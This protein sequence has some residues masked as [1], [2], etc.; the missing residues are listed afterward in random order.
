M[1]WNRKHLVFGMCV[2]FV[3][4]SAFAGAASAW[5]VGE[6]ES[7]HAAVGDAAVMPSYENTTHHHLLAFD[8]PPQIKEGR[9]FHSPVTPEGI[10]RDMDA[11]IVHTSGSNQAPEEEWNR[12]FGG[13]AGDEGYSVQQISDGEYIITGYT[14]S[15]GAGNA[16]VWLIKTDSGGNELWNR[17]FGGS[18]VD[19]GYSV[20]QISD[21]G[22][23]IA[24]TTS[25]YGAGREDVWLIKTDSEGNELWNRTFGG[26]SLDRGSSVQ[27][28]SDGGY[29]IAGETYSYGAGDYDAWLIKTDSE[30]NELWT[31]TFGGPDWDKG[32]S[33]QQTSDGEY[34]IT[35]YTCSYGAGSADV[36]LIKTDSEGNKEWSKTFGGSSG[37]EGYSVR[38]TSDGGYIITGWTESYGAG[39]YDVLLIKTDSEGNKEWSKTFGGS[40]EDW[41]NSVQQTSDGGYIIAGETKSYGAGSFDVWLIKVKGEEPTEL[42][43]HNLNTGEDFATIQA[44]IDDNDTKN[45]HTITVD[46]G[47]YTENVDVTKSLT[48]KSTSGNPEDT[49]VQAANPDD[50]VFEIT[51][52]YVN[53]SGFTVEGATGTWKAG[54]Y[55]NGAEYSNVSGNN[56]SGNYDGI[57]GWGSNNT[58]L[59]NIAVNNS[60]DGIYLQFETNTTL[61]NN[62]AISNNDSGIE[63]CHWSYNNTLIG[64]IA[65]NNTNGIF[66]WGSHYAIFRNNTM[67]GN[68]YN[69]GIGSYHCDFGEISEYIHDIDTSNTVDGKPIYYNIGAS[70]V[71]IDSSINAGYIAIVNGSNV[72]VKDIEM[73]NNVNGVLFALTSNSYI[74]NVNALNNGVGISLHCSQN[75]T[76]SG[77][78]IGNN[79]DGIEFYGSNN[80][81]NIISGNNI[82]DNRRGIALWLCNNNIVYLNNFINN[83]NNVYSY[84]STNTWNS[85]SKITYTYIDNQYTNYLGNYWDDYKGSDAN[86]D[87]IGDT[88]YSIG[89]D[90]DY[91]PLMKPFESYIIAP[92]VA[93]FDTGSPSNPYPS[94]AG[95]HKGT[96][97]PNQTITVNKLYTYPCPGTGGHTESIELYENGKL[98]ANGTWDGYAGD[99]HNITIHNVSGAPYVRLL[100][101]HRYNYTIVTGSYPQ[102][103]HTDALPTKNGWINCTEFV[104]AN[105]KVYYDWIPAIKLS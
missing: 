44:A 80:N 12:T 76:I 11:H 82:N 54:I 85:T 4:F 73:K 9:D 30:G 37:D 47:T 99:W 20:Q 10:R 32:Y 89:G 103:H 69:F 18:D 21:G 36:W 25:S 34:I 93:I 35:G 15:Y 42:K 24:G 29:I 88:P 104:D 55:I 5:H 71:I 77:N 64:N 19:V 65:L 45:G 91:Y 39:Y 97:T 16:D 50:H 43:V 79:K 101:G 46:P 58:L 53:I 68:D 63:I 52:N 61:K 49:I 41:S 100:K 8:H 27:Q 40:D 6:G 51:A 14:C 13:S 67:S 70:N 81:N 90:K 33:V 7:V 57:A 31:K 87:G 56:A 62:I 96:I 59:S 83:T 2:A 26:S 17:T 92:E 105:G 95:T 3:L 102:I 74:E 23:I 75:N 28:T 94:I 78:N 98:I 60:E 72:T 86:G 1:R 48:I 66:M 38:Q 84:D 22:Y